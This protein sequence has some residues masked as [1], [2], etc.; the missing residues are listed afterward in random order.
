MTTCWASDCYWCVSCR[1]SSVSALNPKYGEESPFSRKLSQ[2]V[3]FGKVH[4]LNKWK[5]GEMTSFSQQMVL[6]DILSRS[7]RSSA[8]AEH[9]SQLLFCRNIVTGRSLRII[10]L[11]YNSVSRGQSAI[12]QW[13]QVIIRR[14]AGRQLHTRTVQRLSPALS[15][16]RDARHKFA[17]LDRTL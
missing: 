9:V 11:N 1:G 2:L 6:G 10:Q 12:T 16:V 4:F 7:A 5:S 8:A 17:S 13:F 15:M 14:D 3:K